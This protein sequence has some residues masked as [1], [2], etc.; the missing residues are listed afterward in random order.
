MFWVLTGLGCLL[1]VAILAAPLLR[2]RVQAP[3]RA[4]GATA[5]HA[6]LDRIAADR[7]SGL[8]TD[9][10]AA[11]AEIEAE[12]AALE[13]RAPKTEATP[14]KASRFAAF[15]FIGASPLAA[16]WLYFLVGA[17]A[18]I[19]KSADSAPAPVDQAMIESMVSGL[20]ARLT[21][22]PDDPDGWRMLARSYAVMGRAAES[23]AAWRELAQRRSLGAED[24]RGYIGALLEA[25]PGDGRK[26]ELEAAVARLNE[27]SPGDPMA[28]YFL[29]LK[30]RAEGDNEKAIGYW[31]ALLE[32]LPPEAPVRS[33][34]E[35]LLAEAAAPPVPAEPVPE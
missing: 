25:G 22:N 26:E 17:P 28:L 34:I 13:A 30:A 12:R 8:I 10:A 1:F 4:L 19:G 31:R 20:A 7:A 3:E 2:A 14:S 33:E 15:A 5:L 23:A 35:R 6:E 16:L 11:E 21:E 29:G 24:L 9:A 18:L 32:R 27:I